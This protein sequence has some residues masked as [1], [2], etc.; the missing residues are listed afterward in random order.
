MKHEDTNTPYEY[1]GRGIDLGQWPVPALHTTNSR[2]KS[3]MPSM[4]FE[5][6]IPTVDRRLTYV[7][8][9]AFK[10]IGFSNTRDA[11]RN[12]LNQMGL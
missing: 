9:R 2:D 12:V 4:E 7:L 5:P 6:R 1:T 11:S 8:N 3:S 10:G